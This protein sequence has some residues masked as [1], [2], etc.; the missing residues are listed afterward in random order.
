MHGSMNIKFINLFGV[1]VD[2]T[3]CEILLRH[4][5]MFP[6]FAISSY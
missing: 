2:D 5:N 6:R 1:F 3:D 4:I